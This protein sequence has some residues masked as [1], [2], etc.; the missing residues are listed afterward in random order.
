VVFGATHSAP[1]TLAKG[2]VVGVGKLPFYLPHVAS[3]DA[4]Q[5]ETSRQIKASPAIIDLYIDPTV[6]VFLAGVPIP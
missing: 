1:V 4:N 6:G 3:T 5:R 2:V